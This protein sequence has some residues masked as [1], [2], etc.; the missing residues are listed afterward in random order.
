MKAKDAGRARAVTTE[1]AGQR[2]NLNGRVGCPNQTG[3]VAG[4]ATDALCAR[5]S[6]FGGALLVGLIDPIDAPVTRCGR[7]NAR[8]RVAISG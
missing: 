5:Y 6:G 1:T 4:S 2:G 7:L 8:V 3:S